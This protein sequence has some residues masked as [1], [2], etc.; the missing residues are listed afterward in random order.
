MLGQL[1]SHTPSKS[2]QR[3]YSGVARTRD[4]LKIID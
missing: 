4:L 1:M 2:E 3:G